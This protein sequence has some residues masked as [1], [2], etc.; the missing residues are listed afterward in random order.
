FHGATKVDVVAGVTFVEPHVDFAGVDDVNFLDVLLQ[1]AADASIELARRA[2]VTKVAGSWGAAD[3]HDPHLFE[4]L[5]FGRD[6]L[7]P[8]PYIDARREQQVETTS[9][10]NE[11]KHHEHQAQAGD[12]RAAQG[13]STIH[14]YS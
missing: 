9:R 1:E 4:G 13:R 2:S 7:T 10:G 8:L 14:R 6:H 5:A 12:H 3:H 11:G